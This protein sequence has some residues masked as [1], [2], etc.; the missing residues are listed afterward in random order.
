MGKSA[1]VG[2]TAFCDSIMV[3]EKLLTQC[4][5]IYNCTIVNGGKTYCIRLAC[6]SSLCRFIRFN[7]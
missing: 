5:Q 2:A 3:K 4:T 6:L 1:H 7:F